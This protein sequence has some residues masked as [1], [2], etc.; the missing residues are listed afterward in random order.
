MQTFTPIQYLMIDVASNYGHG[1]ESWDFRI[2]WFL[3][4][5]NSLLTV[6]DLSPAGLRASEWMR[7]A[8]E[9]ALFYA[10][11]RAYADALNNKSTSY[12]ISL[13]ATASGAQILSVLIG[14]RKSAANCN[15]VDTGRR[16]NLYSNVSNAMRTRLEGAAG[17]ISEADAKQATMTL[18]F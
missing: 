12:P 16:E 3:S 5:E 1:K 18:E 13:D 7:E 11:L 2:D 15:V 9:P 6:V 10:G 17:N 14:C 4:C 8:D